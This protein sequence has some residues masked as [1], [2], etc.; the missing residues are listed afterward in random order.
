MANI[1]A[2]VEARVA[3]AIAALEAEGS[4]ASGHGVRPVVEPP[5]DAAHGDVAT[6]AALALTK[7]AGV[8]PRQLAARLA[9]LLARA[10]EIAQAEVAGPG[11]LN[12][13]L[14]RD[15][16][17][18][19]LW[20]IRAA[21]DT[22]GKQPPRDEALP[23]NVE[24]VSANP[25]GPMHVGHCRG[26]VV[27]DALA[28]LLAFAGHRV[29]REYYVNDAGAQVDALA[30]SV[31]L[32]YREALGEDIGPIPEGLYPGDYLVPVGEALAREFGDRFLG[33][34]EAE[35]LELF[36]ARAVAAMM[37]C[38]RSDLES[39]G[40]RHDIFTS[41]AELQARGAP[42]AA[43][44]RLRAEG[45]V[46]DGTLPPPKGEAQEDWE[47]SVLPLFRAT[48]FGDDVDRPIRK[49]DGSWTYFGADMAYHAE[50][51]ARS[52]ALID[53]WGADHSGTVKRIMAAVEALSGGRVPF[54]VKLVQMVR[55]FRG[56]EPVRMSKR[57][58]NFVSLA[59]VVEEVGPDVT[60]FMMLTKRP[61]SPLDF[62][63]V[64]AVEQ[65]RE[66]PVFY[67]QY[68][69]AR[70]RSVERRAEGLALPVPA[71]LDRLDDAEWDL[72]KRMAQWPR[73]VEQA[74]TAREPHRIAFYLHDLASAF[75]ALWNRGNDDPMFRIMTDDPGL[76]AAR[77]TLA[78][79]VGQI[80]RAG[81]SIMGVKAVEELR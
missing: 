53:I 67:V 46:Y 78:G 65:S 47:P 8:P 4:I 21:G 42:A 34:P 80:L 61:E 73:L 26:A 66:N 45:L 15:V 79:A 27:G 6:N 1:F 7:A 69:H 24:F 55:I 63:Y 75:H 22:Y 33:R 28:N 38:I 36:R 76:T 64:K 44:A 37:D 14:A 77:L 62:D 68:A 20:T 71:P 43:E 32:R 39:L 70:I 12:L 40:I 5:R 25:T 60:R 29:V 54:D 31:H 10:P 51:A 3:E 72:V 2:T 59:D 9:M 74:A 58:G 52:S 35:W 57:A 56:G 18:Q 81:L 30:R 11:F 19:E 13:T 23:I 41:E 16:W 48:A 17:A 50:K 49:S